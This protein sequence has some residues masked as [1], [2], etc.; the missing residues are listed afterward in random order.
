RSSVRLDHQ[1]C[2]Q[3]PRQSSSQVLQSQ[4]ILHRVKVGRL[5]DNP[6]RRAQSA[7]P[8]NLAAARRVRKLETFA[9][10]GKNHGV[11]ADHVAFANRL[12]WN[13]IGHVS[14]LV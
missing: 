11:L 10:S 1:D 3:S 13:L 12:N 5:P 2:I 6:L 8:E 7:A 4:Y 14:C 9:W